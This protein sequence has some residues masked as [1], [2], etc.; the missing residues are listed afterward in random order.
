MEGVKVYPS[1]AN[2]FLM[3][4]TKEG[5]TGKEIYENLKQKGILVRDRSHLPLCENCLRVTIGT[6]RMNETFIEALEET[7]LE[8]KRF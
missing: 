3:R 8:K 7:L 6:R 4:V 1:Q 5:F 2:F